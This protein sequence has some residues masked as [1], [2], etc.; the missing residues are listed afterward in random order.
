MK[1]KGSFTSIDF[2]YYY[3]NIK[4]TIEL[5]HHY[6]RSVVRFFFRWVPYFLDWRGSHVF[7]RHIDQ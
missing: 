3:S 2:I 1:W 4:L 5:Y 7:T 6:N